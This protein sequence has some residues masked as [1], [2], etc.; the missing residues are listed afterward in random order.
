MADMDDSIGFIHSPESKKSKTVTD[1]VEG[2]VLSDCS[3]I[4]SLTL[5][6]DNNKL[7]EEIQMMLDATVAVIEKTIQS[8]ISKGQQNLREMVIEMV[9]SLSAESRREVKQEV[10]K[11]IKA[12]VKEV[13]T[14]VVKK[15]MTKHALENK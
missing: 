7:K 10:V 6:T 8:E 11:E 3:C 1:D 9:K 14:S 13:I 12:V 2:V 4:K 15:E 5:N